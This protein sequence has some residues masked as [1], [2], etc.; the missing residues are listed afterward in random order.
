MVKDG[1]LTPWSEFKKEVLKI[2]GDYN[3]RWLETEYHQTVA[4]ANMTE[5]WKSFET[6][7]DLYPNLKLISVRDKTRT[8]NL[9]RHYSPNQ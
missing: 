3:H 1:K 7:A 5:K 2:S 8:Q 4:N 9:R 6:N